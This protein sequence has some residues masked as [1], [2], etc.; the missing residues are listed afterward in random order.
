LPEEFIGVTSLKAMFAAIALFIEQNQERLCH[1]NDNLLARLRGEDGFG[2]ADILGEI[3]KIEK[4]EDLPQLRKLKGKLSW[5]L[6]LEEKRTTVPLLDKLNL[7][8]NNIIIDKRKQLEGTDAHRYGLDDDRHDDENDRRKKDKGSWRESIHDPDKP[9]VRDDTYRQNAGEF[10]KTHNPL[11]DKT[12][13][14]SANDGKDDFK[15]SDADKTPFD[16]FEENSGHKYLTDEEKVWREY[17]AFARLV[18]ALT[19]NMNLKLG[20]VM[21]GHS[22][23]A[24][25]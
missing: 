6:T 23:G 16:D 1:S 24:A 20:E 14:K 13:K 9:D 2:I 25:R 5:A 12:I 19:S 17:Q 4:E 8:I 22:A 7:V 10:D 15:P 18:K 21:P 11:D 3:T